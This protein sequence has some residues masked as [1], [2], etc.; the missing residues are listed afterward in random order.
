MIDWAGRLTPFPADVVE[1]YRSAGLWG[2]RPIG[3]EFHEI[4]VG[5]AQHPAVVAEEGSLTY[6]ELDEATDRLAVGLA[7][8]G[9]VPGDRV[10]VQLT[11]RLHSVVAWYGMLKAGLVP[12]CTLAAHRAHEIGSISRKVG[13]VAHLVESSPSGFDLVAFALD[14]R[15]G[16]PTMRHVLTAGAPAGAS[17]TPIERLAGES[18]PA[19]ARERV[20]AIQAAIDPDEIACFQ[21]SGGTTGAPKI[22]PRLHA[23]Y[24]YN[25]RAFAEVGG[26]DESTRTAHLIPIIHNAGI[27]CGLHAVHSVGGTLVLGTAV[28]DQA[29]PLVAREKTT[30]VLIGHGHYNIVD[31]PLFDDATASMRRVLLSGA[32]VPVRVFEPFESRGILVGQMFG[33]GEGFF[34]TSTAASTREARLTTVGVPNSPYDEFR[35]LEPGTEQELPDGTVG[36]LVTRGPYTI[37]GYFDAPDINA[38]AFTSDGFYRTGDLVAVRTLGGERSLVVEGRLKDLISRGGEKISAEE[39]ENLLLRHPRIVAAALVAMPDERLGE[40]A[41]A[42][43]VAAGEPLTM[44]EVQEHLNALSLAKFKW[45]ERLEWVPEMPKTPVGKLDKKF[46]HRDIVAKMTEVPR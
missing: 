23:E 38:T 17:G 2:T 13:A 36:E 40:R 16:H 14:Q 3:A 46:L 20:A 41:C 34:A 19:L 44:Q 26:W 21:L 31:H 42:Y 10:V 35:V 15:A 37:R 33:M 1:R 30:D 28:L 39:V 7:D 8:L 45:P 32:K 11:N 29:L 9:L 22:I 43:L 5:R 18:D 6:S 25:A 27:T 4:A 12:V 24:W